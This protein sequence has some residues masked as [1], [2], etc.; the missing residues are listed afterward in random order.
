[1]ESRIE[2]MCGNILMII[3]DLIFI[4]GLHL[5]ATGAA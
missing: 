2:T 3:C 1:M 4:L 5:G